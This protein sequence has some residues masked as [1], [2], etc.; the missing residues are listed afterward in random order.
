MSF[1]KPSK[2]QLDNWKRVQEKGKMHFIRF[3]F[4]SFGLNMMVFVFAFEY[5]TTKPI[6]FTDIFSKEIVIKAL[7]SGV[8]GGLIYAF[9]S[10]AV[11]N[12][13]FGKH[14]ND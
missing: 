14:L 12:W 13:R 5:I 10:W 11:G 7:I 2:R 3:N 9:G 8:V 4:I 1:L 6:N